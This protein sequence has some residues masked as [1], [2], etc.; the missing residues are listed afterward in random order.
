MIPGDFI[1]HL[2]ISV[3]PDGFVKQNADKFAAQNGSSRF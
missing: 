2:L 1:A 3:N